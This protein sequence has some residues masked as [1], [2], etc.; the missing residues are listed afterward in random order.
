MATKRLPSVSAI[1]GQLD[2]PALISWAANSACDYIAGKIEM[3]ERPFDPGA[4]MIIIN[5]ARK[6]YRAVS[7]E[8]INIGKEVH[9]AIE[10]HLRKAPSLA[11]SAP[12]EVAYKAFMAWKEAEGI[13]ETIA[14]EKTVSTDAYQGKLDW[15]CMKQGRI[16]VIDF[17]VAKGIY[18]DNRYQVAGYRNA[19]DSIQ[20]SG[21]LRLD[22]E[23]GL[24]EWLD[25]EETYEKDLDVFN[26]LVDL[27][28]ASH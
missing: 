6:N 12:A 3:M 10:G 7:R 17:K 19:D 16:Y 20:G 23:T 21:I 18:D 26:A 5:D 9:A 25:T 1:V 22:R 24:P 4:L 13:T 28:Y 27:W 14:T 2:K 8:A 15:L 11:L